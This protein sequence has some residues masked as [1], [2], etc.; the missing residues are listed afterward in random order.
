[1]L[2][3]VFEAAE[4]AQRDLVADRGTVGAGRAC[5]GAG[6]FRRE[7]IGG[8][9]QGIGCRSVLGCPRQS[10]GPGGRGSGGRERGRGSS[11]TPTGRRIG[12]DVQVVQFL[13][14]QLE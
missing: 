13:R 6:D 5:P 14:V 8:R 3:G 9:R 12:K 4:R 7:R 2:R 11:A 1:R 10:I